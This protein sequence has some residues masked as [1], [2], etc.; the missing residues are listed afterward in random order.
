MGVGRSPTETLTVRKLLVGLLVLVVLA[1]AAIWWFFIND[2]APPEAALP[3]REPDS[4]PAADGSVDGMWEVLRSADET[5]A[6]FRITEQ[7]P[8]FDNTA[9]VRTP[10]VDGALTVDGSTIDGVT[11]TADLTE[12]ESQD[13]QPPGVPGIENRVDQMRNDGLETDTFPTVTFVLTQPIELDAEPTLDEAV[14]ATAVGDLTI[15]GETQSVEIPIEARWNGEVI[16]V[17][18]SLE[19]VLADYGME[20]PERSFVTVGDVGTMEFQLTFVPSI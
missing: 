20:A 9:V 17:A 16:D 3:E 15:H 18:G 2:D 8:G 12:L 14:Q 1:G 6:G 7:F 13:S 5:F 10:S 19:V 4:E 11:I